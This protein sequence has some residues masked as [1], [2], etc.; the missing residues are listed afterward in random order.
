MVAKLNG[1]ELGRGSEDQ[2]DHLK[3]NAVMMA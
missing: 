1:Y 3:T 2:M